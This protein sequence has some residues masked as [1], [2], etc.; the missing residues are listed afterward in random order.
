[1]LPQLASATF[2]SQIFWIL[3]GFVCVYLFMSEV[4]SPKLNELFTRRDDYLDNLK[5][6]SDELRTQA[7]SINNVSESVLEKT[8]RHIRE[9]E[10][11]LEKNLKAEVAAS[12][13]NLERDFLLQTNQEFVSIDEASQKVFREIS[14][15]LDDLVIAAK[16]KLEG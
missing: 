13:A 11:N 7:E 4:V 6:T 9:S 8:Q 16:S 14:E 1:M 15:N 3:W 2:P 10:D 12:R 5:R